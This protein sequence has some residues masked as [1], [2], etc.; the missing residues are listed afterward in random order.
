MEGYNAT[1]ALVVGGEREQENDIIHVPAGQLLIEGE[2]M[3][4][5]Y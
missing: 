4:V 1:A 2:V 3:Y 5:P